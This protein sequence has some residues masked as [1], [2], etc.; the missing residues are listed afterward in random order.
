MG[1]SFAGCPQAMARNGT[2]YTQPE[3]SAKAAG[4][5]YVNDAAPGISRLRAGTGFRY[6]RPDGR[7]LRDAETLARIRKLAIPPAW[8]QVW[9]CTRDDAW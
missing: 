1:T 2:S 3:G 9:I 6:L 7:A 8:E 5:R 4:L